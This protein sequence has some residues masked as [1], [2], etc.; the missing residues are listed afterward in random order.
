MTLQNISDNQVP[1]DEL[2]A[3]IGVLTRR[4]TEARILAPLVEALCEEFDRARVLTVIRDAIIRLAEEQGGELA[5]MMGGSSAAEFEDSL[6]YWTREGALEIDVLERTNEKFSF[7]V[8][9]CRYA[10]LYRSLGIA[11]LGAILSCNRD[12]ALIDGFN[13][14]ASLTRTQTIM[15]G[16]ACCDFRYTFPSQPITLHDD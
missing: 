14:D 11:D 12:F 8:T 7:N 6:Q 9:R 4:E 1:P 2:N 3:K 16:A 15:E 5:T 10:E 13:P